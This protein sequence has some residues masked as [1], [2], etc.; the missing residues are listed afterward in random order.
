MSTVD[1]PSQVPDTTPTFL[2]GG[3]DDIGSGIASK[4]PVGATGLAIL[5]AV[6][7][8]DAIVAL[9]L[10]APAPH[11]DAHVLTSADNGKTLVFTTSQLLTV[12]TELPVGFGCAIKGNFTLDVAGTALV[13]DVREVGLAPPWCSLIQIAA[14]T[15]ELVGNKALPPVIT[16][17]LSIAVAESE[18]VTYAITATNNPTSFGATGLP[19]GLS[20]N[21]GTGVITGSVATAGEYSITLFATNDAGTGSS[22]LTLTVSVAVFG[23]EV[24]GTSTSLDGRYAPAAQGFYRWNYTTSQVE[25]ISGTPDNNGPVMLYNHDSNPGHLLF[26]YETYG[27]WVLA[28]VPPFDGTPPLVVSPYRTVTPHTDSAS[29]EST[30]WPT[31]YLQAYIP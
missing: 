18:E 17:S 6:T 14:D 10:G 28:E 13:T 29:W 25:F 15:Y 19:D 23:F 9:A 27:C 1:F 26:Y 21:T 2:V 30:F 11:S 7:T 5:A 20:I 3:N 8:S 22:V 31:L 12:S 4:V 16:S 24:Y